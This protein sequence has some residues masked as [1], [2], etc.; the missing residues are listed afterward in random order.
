LQ[1]NKRENLPFLSKRSVHVYK[2]KGNARP[3]SGASTNTY[4]NED[5][6]ETCL[7]KAYHES[8]IIYLTCGFNLHIASLT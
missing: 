4:L 7:E 2:A 3:Q 6:F 8:P 5:L 1:G